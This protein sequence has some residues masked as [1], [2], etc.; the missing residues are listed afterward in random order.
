MIDSFHYPEQISHASAY[1][2]DN[3][4]GCKTGLVAPGAQKF[5]SMA[6]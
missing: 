2:Q 4:T 5:I 3:D 1:T 6:A